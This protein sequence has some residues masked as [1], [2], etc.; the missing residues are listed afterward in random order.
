ME[1]WSP[2]AA[3]N[4]G[5][6]GIRRDDQ[7]K[8]WI[9]KELPGWVDFTADCDPNLSRIAWAGDEVAGLYLCRRKDDVG[10]VANVAVRR[11]YRMQGLSRSLMFHCLYAM[12]DNDI[13]R[14]RVY[15]GIGADRDAEP[16]GPYKMYLGFGFKLLTFHNR[17]R[18]PISE[19]GQ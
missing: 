13:V 4:D 19:W 7:T 1:R 14:A 8:E 18:K 3:W 2:T 9:E 11:A 12:R 5:G 10:D 15:T 16:S 17:Y 6:S